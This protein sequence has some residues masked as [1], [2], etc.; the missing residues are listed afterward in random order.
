LIIEIGDLEDQEGNGSRTVR[1]DVGDEVYLFR[2]LSD[3]E[4]WY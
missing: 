4:S 3:G 2:I 1:G